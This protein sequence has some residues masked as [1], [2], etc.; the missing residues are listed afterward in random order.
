VY[1]KQIYICNSIAN[2]VLITQRTYRPILAAFFLAVYAFIA[3]PVQLWHHH[4]LNVKV[5]RSDAQMDSVA[6]G[7]SIAL[8]T[9]CPLCSHKYAV[10]NDPVLTSYELTLQATAV[11]N[12]CYLLP[13]LPA[14]PTALPNKGPPALS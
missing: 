5:S 1:N 2:I 11:K 9:D 10:Y 13:Q 6:H 12:G 7:A 8:D 4:Q 3:T 14:S